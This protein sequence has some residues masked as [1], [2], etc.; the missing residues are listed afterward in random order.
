M[1]DS[2]LL[3]RDRF[4]RPGGAILPDLARLYIAGGSE[5]ITDLS[6][7]KNVYGFDMGPIADAV[8]RSSMQDVVVRQVDPSHVCTESV[9]IKTLDLATMTIGD[10]EFST[11]FV[12][13]AR[14]DIGTQVA[15][16]HALVLWFDT[17]FS[18]R[19]CTEY[20][21]ELRTG[22]ADPPTHWAQAVMPMPDPIE[23]SCRDSINSGDADN[24]A[25]SIK[26]RVSMARA[27]GHH[28]TLDISMEYAPVWADGRV[29]RSSVQFYSMNVCSKQ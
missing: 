10:Q 22:P 6:F 11:E 8:R 25:V 23:L 29:G 4:L 13:K 7:W 5:K 9:C 3:A 20:P 24:A 26:G 18:D 27:S 28:R 16:C 1:L 21:Q 2:V 17:S 14:R 15:A 12:L 19:F